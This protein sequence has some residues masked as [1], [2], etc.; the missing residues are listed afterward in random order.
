MKKNTDKEWAIAEYLIGELS[1][2][3]LAEKYGVHIRTVQRWLAPYRKRADILGRRNDIVD[4]SDIA[5]LRK[6]LIKHMILVGLYEDIL[7]GTLKNKDG[8]ICL[9]D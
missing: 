6:E 5:L 9:C 2:K 8:K 7:Q 3:E 4:S 1:E